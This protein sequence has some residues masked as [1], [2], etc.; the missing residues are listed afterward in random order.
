MHINT[1][2]NKGNKLFSVF[3]EVSLTISPII[4]DRSL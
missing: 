3:Q 2:A 1:M 4:Y